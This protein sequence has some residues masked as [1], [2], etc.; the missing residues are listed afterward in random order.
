[1]RINYTWPGRFH[2]ILNEALF[3]VTLWLFKRRFHFMKVRGV[4][5]AHRSPK[6]REQVQFLPHLP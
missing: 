6:P 1:M 4:T 5:V 2:L 3:Y